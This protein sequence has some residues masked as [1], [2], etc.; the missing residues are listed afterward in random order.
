MVIII[1]TA[2]YLAICICTVCIIYCAQWDREN[3][4]EGSIKFPYMSYSAW[5]SSDI[6]L[7]LESYTAKR[8]DTSWHFKLLT[9]GQR[10][11]SSD[12]SF[13]KWYHQTKKF[14]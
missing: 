14:K 10:V 8:T 6:N 13:A 2:S 5:K 12:C 3:S 9:V 11:Y 1:L 7:H 4:T